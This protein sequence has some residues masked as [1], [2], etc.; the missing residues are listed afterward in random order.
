MYG[1]P[2]C[3]ANQSV[4]LFVRYIL[5]LWTEDNDLGP[6][7]GYRLSLLCLTHMLVFLPYYIDFIIVMKLTNE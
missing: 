5:Y 4:E 6:H 2:Y 3:T 7:T 1:K